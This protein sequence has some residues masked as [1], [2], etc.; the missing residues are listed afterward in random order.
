MVVKTIAFVQR[1]L[2][3]IDATSAGW[4]CGGW[5]TV[6]VRA[7]VAVKGRTRGIDP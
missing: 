1:L 3:P 4:K 6:L 7:R 2:L 5:V